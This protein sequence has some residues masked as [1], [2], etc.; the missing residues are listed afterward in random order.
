MKSPL[1][2]TLF[3]LLVGTLVIFSLI[4]LL[5]FYLPGPWFHDKIWHIL[6]FFALFTLITTLVSEK[7]MGIND[8]N[9]VAVIL[10]TA[11]FR[12]ILSVGFVFFILW[13]GDKNILWFVVDFF[14]IYLL[15]L[16]FDIYSLITNLRLHSK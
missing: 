7:F 14:S 5:Q 9:S 13:R 3:R 15:Y 6:I 10:G 8:Y 16:L 2:N 12:F 1:L 11:V 4:A